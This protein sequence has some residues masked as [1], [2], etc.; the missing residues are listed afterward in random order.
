MYFDARA[1]AGVPDMNHI[2]EALPNLLLA[3]GAYVVATASPGPATL[4]ISATSMRSGRKSGLLLALG[5]ICGS[6]SWA[7]LT[8][9]GLT[10]VI[11][12][13]TWTLTALKVAGGFY[14]LWLAKKSLSSAM[15]REETPFCSG[16]KT[17]SSGFSHF[18]RGFAIHM[19]N[20]KAVLSWAAIIALGLNGAANGWI[21]ITLIGGCA[22]LGV[23]I[24]C[25]YAVAFSSP[26]I[27]L[28]YRRLR[29]PLETFMAVLFGFAGV[30]LLTSRL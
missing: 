21:T 26:P 19:T 30:R 14:L 24:F 16:Q 12:N 29:R 8:A 28:A 17:A 13:F 20:P 27:V 10:A 9:I 7:F 23:T 6:L 4:A 15:T 25:G 18:L 2:L 1:F 11:A 5:V 22:L 3:Y